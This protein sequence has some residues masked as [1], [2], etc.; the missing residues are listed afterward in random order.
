M[1]LESL[2]SADQSRSENRWFQTRALRDL[3]TLTS[4]ELAALDLS[5]ELLERNAQGVEATELPRL[6]EKILALVPRSKI[7]RVETDHE[8]LLE[9]QGLTSVASIGSTKPEGSDV[10]ELCL[11]SRSGERP[12]LPALLMLRADV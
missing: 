11:G 7:A 4:D 8:A 3:L 10:G 5:I 12:A 1:H 2:S 6:R 9:A